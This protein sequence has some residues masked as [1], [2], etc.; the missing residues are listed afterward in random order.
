MPLGM[1]AQNES[2]SNSVNPRYLEDQ[3]YLGITYN[4]L[5]N[6]PEG[7]NQQNLSYGLQGGFI[8]DI[9]LNSDSTIGMGVG[10]GL[11]LNTYYTNIRASEGVSGINY[12][13]I[14]EGD[15]RR[16]KI[17]THS[18]EVPLEFRW[19]NS[20]ETEYKFWRVYSGVKFSYVYDARSKF[21]PSEDSE[22]LE[23]SFSN[24]DIKNLQV[25]LTLNFGYNS[26]NAHVYYSLTNLFDDNVVLGQENIEMK[27][28]RIGLIF[29]IL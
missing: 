26:F 27:P 9:P 16:S 28:L 5:L 4:F 6:Q 1:K 3:F 12:T 23:T 24:P 15:A 29:Y 21:V 20:T 2:E 13:I 11:G 7:V 10:L 22:E 8:K 17:E 14:D 25:G 18:I 19:R